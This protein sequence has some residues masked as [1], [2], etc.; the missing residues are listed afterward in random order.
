MRSAVFRSP[1]LP[2]RITI[3][4]WTD[5]SRGKAPEGMFG[6]ILDGKQGPYYSYFKH[7]RRVLCDKQLPA[8]SESAMGPAWLT[9]AVQG[10]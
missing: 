9:A 10:A 4:M 7:M 6:G 1:N 8:G 3:S 2:C 5:T